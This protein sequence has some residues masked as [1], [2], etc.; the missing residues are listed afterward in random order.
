MAGRS[1]TQLVEVADPAWP[2]VQEWIAGA[3]RPVEV[4]APD[5]GCA[6]RSLLRLQVTVGSP[7]GALAYRTGGLLVDSGWLR[8]LGSGGG[9]RMSGGL[10]SWNNGSVSPAD[11]VGG[12]LVV[13]HDAV[14]GFFAIDG[15]RLGGRPGGVHYLT[16]D[17]LEWEDL[18]LSYSELLHW[19]FTGDLDGFYRDAR[20]P[21]WAEEVRGLTGDQGILVYPP[22]WAE[23]GPLT[24]RARNPVP[25]T[26]M[27]GLSHDWKRQLSR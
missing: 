11:L 25:M 10:E 5:Q 1:L 15:G 9:A 17:S 27:W 2:S 23:G 22:L 18:D 3:D 4:I 19:A 12:A 7:L 24:E 8:L 26:E 14:G 13:G 16:P 21:T 6:E 20:W